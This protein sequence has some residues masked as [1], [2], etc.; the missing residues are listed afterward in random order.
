M[1]VGEQLA[2]AELPEGSVECVHGGGD[3]RCR[4]RRAE[5]GEGER[6]RLVQRHR[7]DTVMRVIAGGSVLPAGAEP[8]VHVERIPSRVLVEPVDHFLGGSGSAVHI[9]VVDLFDE[10]HELATFRG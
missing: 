8:V 6:T 5:I 9:G 7:V 2:G 10:P 1:V 3:L 4:R